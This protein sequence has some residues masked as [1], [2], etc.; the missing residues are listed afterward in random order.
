MMITIVRYIE[1][2][3][4]ETKQNEMRQNKI[5]NKMINRIK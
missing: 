2:K 3:L 1:I 5:I 4:I